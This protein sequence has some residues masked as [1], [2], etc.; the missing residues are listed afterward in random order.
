MKQG[1]WQFMSI[2]MLL[3]RAKMVEVDDDLESF[4]YVILYYAARYLKSNI[5]DVGAFIE[6]FFDSYE[7]HDGRYL[8]GATKYSAILK[9]RRAVRQ[10]TESAVRH[11]NE[12][13]CTV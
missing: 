12:E 11:G 5:T 3:K 4:F 13:R 1:T 10:L 2:D 8:V 6:G 7:V 9:L